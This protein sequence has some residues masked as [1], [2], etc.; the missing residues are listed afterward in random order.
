MKFALSSVALALAVSAPPAAVAQQKEVTLI[1]PGG[2]RAA[3]EQLIPG[4]EKKTGIKVKATFGSGLG[5]KKQVAQG[6]A[7]DVPILQ[8]PYSEVLASGNVI[9]GSA[10]T[11]AE[12]AVGVAVKTGAPKPDFSTPEAAKRALLA[13][14]SVSYPNPAGGAAAGVSFDE[15]L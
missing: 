6:D 13:A 5:T 9:A 2:I 7:F 11:L 15:T 12:V 4:F 8:P 1:A 14:K 10:K 3:I